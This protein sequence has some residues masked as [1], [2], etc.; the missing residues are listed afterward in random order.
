VLAGPAQAAPSRDSLASLGLVFK[1]LKHVQGGPCGLLYQIGVPGPPRCT[2]GPDPGPAGVDVRQRRPLANLAAS[3]TPRALFSGSPTISLVPCIGDGTSGPRVQAIYAHPPGSPDRFAQIAPLIKT[4]ASQVDE[5]Y[6]RSAAETGGARNVRFVTSNCDLSVLDIVA[7]ADTTAHTFTDLINLGFTR[8]ERK[9]LVWMDADEI[10]GIGESY[11]DSRP[12][13]FNANNGPSDVPGMMARVDQGCWGEYTNLTRGSTEAHE[14]THTLGAVLAGAPN[15]TRYG[16]CDDAHDVM[17]Y[18]DG[19]GTV[20][21]DACPASHQQLLDCNHDDYFNTN[22]GPGNYVLTHWNTANNQFLAGAPTDTVAPFA[23]ALAAKVKKKHVVKLRF[24]VSDDSGKA[25]I[26]AAV[27]RGQK[28]I[29]EWGPEELE[30]GS[31]FLTWKAP[32]KAQVLNFCL[33]AQ[34][35]SGNESQTSCASLRVTK[36]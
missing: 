19:E 24:N 26:V 20:L 36:R 17:C 18:D 33:A 21:H 27:F 10:C 31:Y 9:Y 2:H 32:A 4:W 5:T 7:R 3:L 30:S 34:D 1:G 16:H 14:L 6:S 11:G 25:S 15:A 35:A 8:H 22:P 23:K 28:Q 13:L 12:G 29:R